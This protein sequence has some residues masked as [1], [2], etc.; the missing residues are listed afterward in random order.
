MECIQKIFKGKW[1]GWKLESAILK[2]L[3]TGEERHLPV[4]GSFKKK[5][6]KEKFS[7]KEKN[8]YQLTVVLKRRDLKMMNGWDKSGQLV[9]VDKNMMEWAFA[10][11][12]VGDK[13]EFT[14]A[15]TDGEDKVVWFKFVAIGS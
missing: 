14:A 9:T 10:G 1:D 2:I 11:C 5:T 3:E 4:N 12:P 15:A 7:V 13:I 8:C 6:I